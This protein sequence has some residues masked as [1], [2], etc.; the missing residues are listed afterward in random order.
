MD[1]DE[2]GWEMS[3]NEVYKGDNTLASSHC[4]TASGRSNFLEVP[5]NGMTSSSNY[6]T[7]PRRPKTRHSAISPTGHA[8]VQPSIDSHSPLNSEFEST[9]IHPE[10]V[11]FNGYLLY[12]RNK[13]WVRQWKKCWVVLRV[14]KL[15]F[16]KNEQEYSAMKIISIDE[17]IDAADIDPISRS[18]VFCFQIITEDTRYR[19]CA[20][21]EAALGKWLGSLKFVLTRALGAPRCQPSSSDVPD[22]SLEMR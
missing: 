20:L 2:S 13:K 12:L 21:D 4:T 10:R 14:G 11:I 22:S 18:K 17:V 3:D 1:G 15:A 19:F 9:N 7:A 8:D 5:G 16:Y 6:S